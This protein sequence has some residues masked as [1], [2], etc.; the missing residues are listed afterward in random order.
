MNVLVT[1]ASVEAFF[2]SGK[3]DVSHRH[4]CSAGPKAVALEEPSCE[5][6][7]RLDDP[8]PESHTA[9][10]KGECQSENRDR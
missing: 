6:A 8:V 2:V 3:D 5:A 9:A 1:A 7:R 4:G 10:Q